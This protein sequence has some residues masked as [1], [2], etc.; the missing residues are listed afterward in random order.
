MNVTRR[1]VLTKMSMPYA[2]KT[3]KFGGATYVL[4]SPEDRGPARLF[5]TAGWTLVAEIPSPGGCMDLL[6]IE[7]DGPV[8]A[9]MECF[10][11]YQFHNGGL[12]ELRP[13]MVDALADT[14]SVTRRA[15]L[16]FGHRLGHLSGTRELI[17]TTL[18]QTK[19]APDDWAHPGQVRA[20]GL[21]DMSPPEVVIPALRRNHG[22]AA[23]TI[24]GHEELWFSGIEGVHA[25][26][27]DAEGRYR[28]ELVMDQ[29]ISEMARVDLDGDRRAELVTIEPFHGDSL[30]V[31]RES[32]NSYSKVAETTLRFGHGLWVGDFCGAPRVVVGNRAGGGALEV[33]T[34]QV[35]PGGGF[36]MDRFSVEEG[37]QTANTVVFAA[38]PSE[39][40]I[41][42][43]NQ[44]AGEVVA[45]TI[46]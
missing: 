9:I 8:F 32:N 31:Y 12:Y 21:E 43:M 15:D 17:A 38:G 1:T 7:P 30:C 26:T 44:L 29:D 5:E 36:H 25:V 14:W 37:V 42:A 39:M 27:I 16:P 28:S 10:L 40:V 11:G 6:Q 13:R 2:I 22:I 34:P 45:Y 41:V 19:D 33:V 18:A 46:Q 4:A 23:M 35:Q 24:H 20:Y 3:V